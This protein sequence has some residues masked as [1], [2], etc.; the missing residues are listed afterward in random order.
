VA[1]FWICFAY[2]VY[3]LFQYAEEHF[4]DFKGSSSKKE[5]LFELIILILMSLIPILNIIWGVAFLSDFIYNI[6]IESCFEKK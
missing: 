3:R 6:L 1:F 4:G 5:P 2:L